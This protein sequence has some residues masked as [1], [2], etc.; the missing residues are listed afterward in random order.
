MALRSEGER[1]RENMYR[2]ESKRE[3]RAVLMRWGTKEGKG[4]Y[5]RL[6][7]ERENE[8]E[9]EGKR[10]TRMETRYGQ[11]DAWLHCIRDQHAFWGMWQLHRSWHL[12]PLASLSPCSQLFLPPFIFINYS[13]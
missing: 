10:L 8:R 9:R 1:E 11:R 12:H 2:V 6:V 13:F 4:L 3:N 7:G 5:R